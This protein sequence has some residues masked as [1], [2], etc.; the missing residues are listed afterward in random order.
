MKIQMPW[1]EGLG[2]AFRILPLPT[3]SRAR[4]TCLV[5]GSM[6]NT[7]NHS[8]WHLTMAC[9]KIWLISILN[10]LLILVKLRQFGIVESSNLR[11]YSISTCKEWMLLLRTRQWSWRG[12]GASCWKIT[13]G[14]RI[15]GDKCNRD[16]RMKGLRF[17][18]KENN[19]R[20]NE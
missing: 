7:T 15:S 10:Q 16:L 17:R 13:I 12:S 14:L 3:N 8:R 5:R 9:R 19:G 11:M 1:V 4:A 18:K 20:V 2:S 6:C